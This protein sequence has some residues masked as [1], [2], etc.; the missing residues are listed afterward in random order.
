MSPFLRCAATVLLVLGTVGIAVPASAMAAPGAAAHSAV[1]SI[2]QARTM[3]LGTVVTVGGTATTPSGWLESSS[4][5]KGFGLQDHSAGI[6]V[7]VATDLNIAPGTRV[8]VT[9]ELRDNF[10]LLTLVPADPTQVD[11]Q[12]AGRSISPEP[13]DT[14]AVNESTEGRLVRVVGAITQAPVSDLPFGYKFFVDDGSGELLIFVSTQPNIDLS[15]LTVG[16]TVSV[17]GF[18]GQFDTHYE[19][20]PRFQSDISVVAGS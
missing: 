3:P 12:G 5:D 18:S 4:F 20:N 19:I 8:Q 10:E 11:V 13:V 15:D 16:D 1:V 17:T 6:Y 9:G 7:S 2:A 14:G